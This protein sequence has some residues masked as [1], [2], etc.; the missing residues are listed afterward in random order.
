MSQYDPGDLYDSPPS[1]RRRRA[2][3]RESEFDDAWAAADED[4]AYDDAVE[5]EDLAAGYLWEDR[6]RLG[7]ERDTPDDR[8]VA[9]GPLPP[10]ARRLR[11]RRRPPRDARVL[12][13]RGPA[14]PPNPLPFWAILL[15]VILGIGAMIAVGLACAFALVV[16]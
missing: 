11:A 7:M 16:A 5:I 12:P 3:R 6:D 15:L 8:P 13:E 2:Y 10:S 4:D 9:L 1:R 14:S